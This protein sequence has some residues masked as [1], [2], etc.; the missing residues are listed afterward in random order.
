MGTGV[1]ALQTYK[2]RSDCFTILTWTNEIKGHQEVT[3]FK[4]NSN[5]Q[6]HS[7]LTWWDNAISLYWTSFFPMHY[8]LTFLAHCASAGIC[9]VRSAPMMCADSWATS[10][11]DHNTLGF[12]VLLVS[13]HA[14]S[15]KK[16]RSFL[17][18]WVKLI[19]SPIALKQL[20]TP[21]SSRLFENLKVLN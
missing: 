11:L 17:I 15:E 16:A 21:T 20:A 6:S 5:T 14:L 7:F 2:T 19:L 3:A 4:H 13:C 12:S 10:H 8:F 1:S 9:T 18:G